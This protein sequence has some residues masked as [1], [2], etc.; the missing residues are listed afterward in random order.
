MNGPLVI[1]IKLGT[2]LRLHEAALLFYILPK[3][4]TKEG[5]RN[6]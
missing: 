6:E 1:T 3:K 2:K 5:G 4:S